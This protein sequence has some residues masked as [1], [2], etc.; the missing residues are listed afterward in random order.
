VLLF[1]STIQ[2]SLSSP[3]VSTM[4]SKKQVVINSKWYKRI[5]TRPS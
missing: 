1:L 3:K 5:F 4:Q 2:S